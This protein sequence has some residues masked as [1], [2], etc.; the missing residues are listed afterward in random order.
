MVASS[1]AGHVSHVET[2]VLP[3]GTQGKR[4]RRARQGGRASSSPS[5]PPGPLPWPSWSRPPACPGPP[6][7]AS[8]WPRP[9]R[10]TAWCGARRRPLRP[11]PAPGRAR[12]G[13]RPTPCPLADAA[14]PALAELRDAT[15]ESVQLYVRDGDQRVCVASLESPHGLRTIVPMGA[16]LPLDRGSAGQALRAADRRRGWPSVGEREPGVAS[17]SAPV[18]DGDGRVLAA[19]SVSGPIERT[20]R[21]ARGERY[22]AA[23]VAAARRVEAALR[24]TDAPDARRHRHRHQLV[25]P[26][27]G[28]A[29]AA[30]PLRGARPARRRWSASAP[31]SG[32]MK[33]LDPDAIE[34]GIAA[35]EPVPADRRGPR[36]RGPGRGHQRGARGREPPR[37]PAPGAW[38]RPASTSRSS[39]ASRRPGSSTSA[40]SRRC[41]SFDRRSLLVDIGGGST[42]ILVGER[43]E[44]LTAR[45]LKLGAIRM[46]DRFFPDGEVDAPARSTRAAPRPGVVAPMRAGGRRGFDVAVASSGTVDERGRDGPRRPRRGAG[47]DA[48]PGRRSP[49][50]ELDDGR[51]GPGRGPPPPR[52][53]AGIAG[54]DAQ[55][56]RH[57][58]RP[59]RSCSSR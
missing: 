33:R 45:S 26:G 55:A 36:R 10:P 46:T 59:G 7:T 58:R 18:R 44:A 34:R 15:G 47:A 40:C 25:P 31:G 6:P 20:T 2:L 30:G 54:L 14:G 28:P 8:P 12:A 22:A 3:C 42:E 37:V 56:G 1:D 32:D 27:R 23:V 21:D 49:R 48:Q 13:P 9:S 16:A 53:A 43:G 5:R 4:C 29:V 24:V 57:H 19:V 35:L 17:V 38:T 39:P 52:S 11:R 51:R 41:R 50:E